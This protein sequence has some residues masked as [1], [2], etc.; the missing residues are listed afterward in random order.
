MSTQPVPSPAANR[1]RAAAK[2]TGVEAEALIS[3]LE[4]AAGG[5]HSTL[6]YTDA[7]VETLGAEV[8]LPDDAWL[9]RR[10]AQLASGISPS[11]ALARTAMARRGQ[12]RAG[13]GIGALQRKGRGLAGWTSVVEIAGPAR[14]DDDLALAATIALSAAACESV[15]GRLL[16]LTDGDAELRPRQLRTVVYGVDALGHDTTLE[17]GAPAT[18]RLVDRLVEVAPALELDAAHLAVLDELVP[19]LRQ[20]RPAWVRVGA[21]PDRAL[22]GVT[23]GFG[24][25][26]AEVALRVVGR[27]ARSPDAI[28]RLG[29]MIDALGADAVEELEFILGPAGQDLGLRIGVALSA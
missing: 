29:A 11:H 19:A 22:P 26:P 1:L 24:P 13:F 8:A 17:L 2:V 5:L 12:I 18:A 6:A 15:R 7:N 3:D 28:I 9:A 27:L 20:T 4:E 16:A 10:M 21:I 23:I 25:Q 14:L